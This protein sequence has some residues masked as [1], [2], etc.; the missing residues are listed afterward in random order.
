MAQNTSAAVMAQRHEPHD[1]LD[2]FPTPSWATRALCEQLIGF[3]HRLH[4]H[5]VWEPACNRGYMARTLSEYFDRVYAS[6]VADYGWDGQDWVAD[7][8]LDW[9]GARPDCDWIITNPPFRLA[10]QFIEHGLR[11]AR[12][13]VAV[14]V[15]T[16]FI[17]CS[18][19]YE[20][21][22]RDCPESYVFPFVERVAIWKGVLLDPDVAV[23]KPDAKDGPCMGKP[24]SATSYSWLVWL[25]EPSG[26]VF[27]RI[28]PC[29]KRLTRAGDYPPL[30]D[31]LREP[32]DAR[33]GGLL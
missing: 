21:L 7:F 16:T 33:Q 15:R 31:H 8:L 3:G 17:E 24:S 14:F 18:G 28:A 27:S 10:A 29:R 26:T 6:D 20:G 19:R 22:F 11:H 1:S 23:W 2:D 32:V 5:H 13:G 30:P 12:V 4:L 9:D 25:K